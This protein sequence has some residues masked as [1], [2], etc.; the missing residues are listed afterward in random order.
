MPD[1]F[2]YG[3]IGAGI[4]FLFFV[5]VKLFSGREKK[6]KVYSIPRDQQIFAQSTEMYD[7]SLQTKKNIR[8]AAKD[9]KLI[10][11]IVEF[12][13]QGKKL[14]A[15]KHVQ[16]KENIPLADAKA[17]VEQAEEIMKKMPGLFKS[18]GNGEEKK[19][20]FESNDSMLEK[21]MK[22]LIEN[23]NF[24]TAI[25]LYREA[26]GVGLAEAKQ[27]CEEFARKNNLRI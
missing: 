6:S 27:Y 5:L 22:V 17:V 26:S 25:K 2:I 1:T 14:E 13:E 4:A 12:M 11:E 10:G 7:P 24:I 8:A 9:F 15:I 23:G 16:Q 19:D 18:E 21:K 3:L 20:V